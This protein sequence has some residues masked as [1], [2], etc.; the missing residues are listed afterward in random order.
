MDISE[1]FKWAAYLL[2]GIMGWFVRVL[3]DAQKELQEDMKKIELHISENYTKRN[4]FRDAIANLKNDFK[5]MSVP[6]FKKLDKIEEYILK[7]HMDHHE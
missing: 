7:R 2:T 5:E 3:W 4:D 1:L 6:L